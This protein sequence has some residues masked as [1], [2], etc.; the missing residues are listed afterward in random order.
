MNAVVTRAARFRRPL[1]AVALRLGLAVAP[2]VGLYFYALSAFEH[3]QAQQHR[4]DTGL[5]IALLLGMICV[6]LMLGFGVDLLV[7]AARKRVAASIASLAIVAVLCVPF[8]WVGCNWFGLG[9]NF[10]CMRIM[11]AFGAFLGLF[12]SGG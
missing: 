10:A 9:D 1:M 4:G 2:F 8:G 12:E 7:Q 5:G 3:A 11:D 6:L